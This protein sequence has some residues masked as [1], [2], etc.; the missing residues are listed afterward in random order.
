MGNG[1]FK[2]MIFLKNGD[3]PPRAPSVKR[4]GSWTHRMDV[5]KHHKLSNLED[6]SRCPGCITRFNGTSDSFLFPPQGSSLVSFPSDLC[7]IVPWLKR[8]TKQK[9]DT[10]AHSFILRRAIGTRISTTSQLCF[11][12][13]LTQKIMFLCNLSPIALNLLFNHSGL[14][15][16][17]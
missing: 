11:N 3:V 9:Y 15:K 16:R 7:G 5:F 2:F 14:N 8:G 6:F 12:M 4:S 1:P 10:I 13:K 17:H